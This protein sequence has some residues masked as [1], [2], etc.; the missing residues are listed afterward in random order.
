VKLV[1]PAPIVPAS[2][3]NVISLPLLTIKCVLNVIDIQHVVFHHQT[4]LKYSSIFSVKSNACLSR[5]GMVS[6]RSH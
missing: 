5:G 6:L 4:S 1:F 2:T 3:S